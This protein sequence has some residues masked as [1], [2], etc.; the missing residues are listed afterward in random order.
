MQLP[1]H[2]LQVILETER[3]ILKEVNPEIIDYVFTQWSDEDIM[4]YMGL[5]SVEELAVEKKKQQGGFTTH[6]INLK[7]FLFISKE[8]NEVIG[9]SHYHVWQPMH[10]RAEIG[11]AIYKE[12]YKNKGYMKEAI[13]A[14]LNYG[15]NEMKLNRVEALIGPANE[16]SI[17]LVKSF[18]FVEEGVLREHYCKNGELQDSICFS[19]LKREWISNN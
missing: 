17:R 5:Q 8:T 3:L 6:R 11:Y 4:S 18:G 7:G 10:S 15:F 2:K 12:E 9:A 19:L 14:M 13:K 16:A 1:S